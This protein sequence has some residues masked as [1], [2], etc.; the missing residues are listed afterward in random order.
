MNVNEC[1]IKFQLCLFFVFT[2]CDI[3]LNVQVEKL[4]R[5]YSNKH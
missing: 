3:L 1:N 2:D 5:L 4:E